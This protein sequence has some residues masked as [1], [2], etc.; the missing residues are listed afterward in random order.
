M[1]RI[2]CGNACNFIDLGYSKKYTGVNFS[3]R[4]FGILILVAKLHPFEHILAQK[5]LF[6][7][8][9]LS[10]LGSCTLNKAFFIIFWFIQYGVGDESYFVEYD[11]AHLS[12][13]INNKNKEFCETRD[14][15]FRE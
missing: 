7:K 8:L 6:E 15:L 12:A 14:I 2:Q 13:G 1:Q 3:R 11:F 5:D 9:C 4:E 10:N